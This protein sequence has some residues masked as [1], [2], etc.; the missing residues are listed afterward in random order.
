MDDL[1]PE[2]DHERLVQAVD[3]FIL[4]TTESLCRLES[5]AGPDGRE[6]FAQCRERILR[7]LDVLEKMAASY[8]SL[9]LPALRA[10]IVAVSGS[11]KLP[12]R[13]R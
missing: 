2:A 5:E 12:N 3:L 6:A 4:D 1:L 7:E 13:P 11:I 9:R 8:R 10:A